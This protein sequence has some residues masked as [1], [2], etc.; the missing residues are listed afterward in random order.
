MTV[1]FEIFIEVSNKEYDLNPLYCESLPGYTWGAGMKYTNIKLQ[2]LQYKDM[3]LFLENNIKGGIS[4]VLG[5]RYVK[6]DDNNKILYIDA[7]SLYGWVMI[8]SLPYDDIKFDTDVE[9]EDS[10]HTP[11]DSDIGYFVECDIKYSDAIAE[12]PIYF[13]HSALKIKLVLETILLIIWIKRTQK[14]THHVKS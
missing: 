8:E 7:I 14:F 2:R 3:I 10:L 11:D 5:D 6:S 13:F 1:I 4:S 9:L 12:K